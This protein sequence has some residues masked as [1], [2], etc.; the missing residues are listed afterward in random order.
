MKKSKLKVTI[1]F[2]DDKKRVFFCAD[3]PSV[4]NW[5]IIYEAGLKRIYIP[6]ATVQE[7]IC[8]VI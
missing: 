7:I 8:E 3:H 5:I 4:G 6:E 1:V 2:R